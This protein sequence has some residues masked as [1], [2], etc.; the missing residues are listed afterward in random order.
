MAGAR[1]AFLSHIPIGRVGRP[2]DIAQMVLFLAS[3]AAEWVT[4]QCFYVYVDGGQSL[5]A[6]PPY[7][8]LV[9]RLL[10]GKL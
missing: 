10:G 7:I 9:E 3:E 6:L 1:E 4:G 8:D 2:E 5:V